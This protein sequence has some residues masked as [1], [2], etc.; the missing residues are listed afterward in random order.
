MWCTGFRPDYR[1]LPAHALDE[2]GVPLQKGGIL[3]ALPG[4]YYA[5]LPDG[6]SLARTGLAAVADNGRY[7]AG[8]I[9]IDHVMR[10]RPSASVIATV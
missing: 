9:H 1:I 4:L 3:G 2:N 7:I 6:D 5:G 10:S 8:Q